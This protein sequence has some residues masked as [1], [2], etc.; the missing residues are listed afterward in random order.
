MSALLHGLHLKS[1]AKR[2]GF[3]RND[4]PVQYP[5]ESIVR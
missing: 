1:G 5:M 3:T 4:M 2:V